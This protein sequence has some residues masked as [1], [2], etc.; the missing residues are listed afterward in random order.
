MSILTSGA[1]AMIAGSFIRVGEVVA[2]DE[3]KGRV[4]VTFDDED[5]ATSYWLQVLVRNTL[6]NHDYWMPD[7]GEDVLCIFFG[8]APEVGFVLGSFYA[9][10]VTPPE[11]SGNKRTI[12]FADD[13]KVTYDRSTH[14]L[15]IEISVTKIHADKESVSIVAPESIAETA[16]GVSV[17][18][19]NV[20]ISATE[21]IALAAP[22]ITLTIGGTTM[23]FNGSS[24]ELTSQNLSFTGSVSI[25]GNLNVAGNISSTGNISASGTVSG[26]N[27]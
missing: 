7:I 25:S 27:I 26:S 13:T 17:N 6:K 12:V 19:S 21:K 22:T 11:S 9:G 14:E 15:D 2:L 1:G 8:D 3:K 24:A 4:R 20:D 10:D 18:A 16:S 5:G 23:V